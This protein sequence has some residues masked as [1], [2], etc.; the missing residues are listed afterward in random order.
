[1]AFEGHK[2]LARIFKCCFQQKKKKKKAYCYPKL[3]IF[4][5][6]ENILLK[7]FSLSLVYFN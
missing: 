6:R 2:K 4:E 7:D 1:M 3:F 5:G